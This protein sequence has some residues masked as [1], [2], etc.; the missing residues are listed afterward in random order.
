MTVGMDRADRITMFTG[1]KGGPRVAGAE[2]S[3]QQGKDSHDGPVFRVTSVVRETTSG[4]GVGDGGNAVVYPVYVRRR[5]NRLVCIVDTYDTTYKRS[6]LR[7][8][9]RTHDFWTGRA[10]TE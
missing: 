8:L 7:T 9:K 6:A 1:P 2:S 3:R 10:S 4:G 5:R